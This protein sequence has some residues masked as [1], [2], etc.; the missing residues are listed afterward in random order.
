MNCSSEFAGV[1]RFPSLG[2]G[3]AHL[4]V[5]IANS[6]RAMSVSPLSTQTEFISALRR[7]FPD[8]RNK[9]DVRFRDDEGEMV[10]MEDEGDW[11]AGVEVARLMNGRLELWVG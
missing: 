1:A 10:D 4:Q 8:L 5:H 11:E 2:C 9:V 3:L 6:T 7:K